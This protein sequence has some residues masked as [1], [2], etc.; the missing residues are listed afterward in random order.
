[1]TA[2]R[3][4]VSHLGAQGDG[5]A[6]APGLPKPVYVPGGVPGDTVVVDDKG[7]VLD[8]IPGPNRAEAVCLHFGLCGGCTLQHVAP[9]LYHGWLTDRI[10]MALQQH[11]ITL[12]PDAI[13]APHVSPP[14]TR[15]RATFRAVRRGK[16]VELGFNVERAHTLVDLSECHVLSPALFG[17]LPALRGLLAKELTDGHAASIAVTLTEAGVD[18]TLGG[19]KRKGL[20]QDELLTRFAEEND[21]ARLSIDTGLGVDVIIER[22]A[23]II[24]FGGV[25]VRLPVGA[26][27]QATPDGEAALQAAVIESVGKAKD[28]ADL[29]AGLGTFALPLSA[30]ARVLAS[31][32]GKVSLEALQRAANE[33]QRP[34]RIE[35]RDLFRRPFTALELKRFQAVVIDPPRA[36]AQA[37]CAEIAKSAVPVVV[38]VSCNPNTFA[39]D[40]RLLI[41]GGYRLERLWPVGQFLWSAH[42]ELVARFTRG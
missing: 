34:V 32:A 38:A 7:K 20:A 14:Q 21:L 13:V 25:A 16:Q 27:L 11:D 24:R 6:P 41:D 35:H 12:A 42:V 4:T 36:G 40:A 17:L 19:L 9:E 26:F 29:F 22:R 33:A 15:R 39:R 1:M 18:L 30:K 5:V 8:L 10:L 2:T 28:V 37:Q 31:D 3:L 23:P